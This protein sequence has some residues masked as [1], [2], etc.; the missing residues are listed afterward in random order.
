MSSLMRWPMRV[1]HAALGLAM[2]ATLGGVL[3]A[4][5]VARPNRETPRPMVIAAAHPL[6]VEAGM[7]VLRRGG[8]AVDAAI[9]VQAMLSLVEPQSSGI[10]GGAFMLRYDAA[11]REIAAYDG[12]ETAPAAASPAMFLGENGQPL[13]RGVAMTSGRATGVPGVVAMLGLVHQQHGRLAW[14]SLFDSTAARADAGFTVS[15]RLARFVRGPFAQNRTADV[16][17]YF[18]RADGQ[19]IEAGDTLRNP[20]YGTFVRELALRGPRWFYEGEVASAIVARTS[21]APIPGSLSVTDI[22]TY[23]PLQRDALCVPYRV[24]RLCTMPPPSSGVGL[25]Q[26]MVMLERTRIARLGQ[27]NPQAWYLFAEASRL[28]YADRDAYVGD[29]AFVD[30]PVAGL[31]DR[32]YVASRRALIGPQASPTITAGSPPRTRPP[33]IDATQEPGGTS[34]FVIHDSHGNAVSMTTTIESFF[35]SGRMVHGFFLNNQMTDF[36]F[37]PTGAN[38][39][40][41]GKRP[42]SSMA[43]ILILD[44]RGRLLGALGSPGGNA[45]PAYIG[46]TLIGLLDWHLPMQQAIDLPNLIARPATITGETTRMA[47]GMAE[48]L[49][50]RGIAVQPVSGE[51]SG[52]HGFFWRGGRWDAAAD[53]RRDGSVEQ[54]ISGPRPCDGAAPAGAERSA[55]STQHQR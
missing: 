7:E 27:D 33:S 22:A 32:R 36:S 9:A 29:P 48:A 39:V 37:L 51:D 15:Q 18:T 23:R 28:M 16:Q 47:P 31:L 1:R 24:Y 44:R 54:S 30:V 2:C 35:G 46:K 40:A 53:S 26:L 5:A 14:S 50:Q 20:A 25:L 43:P 8:D 52:L 17:A 34:H 38:A 4:Q 42:R 55:C 49:N 3:P 13:A 41:P 45:I 6:A 11:T 10:G 21:D 19:L 12:R